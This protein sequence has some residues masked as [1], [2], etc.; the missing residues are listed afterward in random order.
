[1][2][3]LTT[4]I[5]LHTQPQTFWSVLKISKLTGSKIYL[6]RK[7]CFY[8]TIILVRGGK[9]LLNKSYGS[10]KKALQLFNFCPVWVN[11]LVLWCKWMFLWNERVVKVTPHHATSVKWPKIACFLPKIDILAIFV[12]SSY[13]QLDPPWGIKM[14]HI[15]ILCEVWYHKARTY[16][17]LAKNRKND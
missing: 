5:G 4:K 6:D 3:K 17:N 16:Q 2:L 15:V 11:F 8:P 12:I 1:M 14:H 13:A 9:I 10:T 7:K